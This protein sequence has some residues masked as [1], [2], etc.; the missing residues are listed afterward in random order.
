MAVR[1]VATGG[2]V[3][4]EVTGVEATVVAIRAFDKKLYRR[5]YAQVRRAADLV[6]RDAAR[7]A[8]VRSGTMAAGYRLR[9]AKK[10]SRFTFGFIVVN[11]TVQGVLLEFA[12]VG[13]TQQG[14]SLVAG[15]EAKYGPPGRFAWEAYDK[16]E[17]DIRARANASIRAAEAEMQAALNRIG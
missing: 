2:G 6:R 12:D 5:M 11:Q 17:G 4:L 1:R 14:R 10:G 16:N 13:H 9:K 7:L 15:L 3:A 8:P